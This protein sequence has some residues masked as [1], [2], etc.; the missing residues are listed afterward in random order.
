[1]TKI[2][3]AL[4]EFD[5]DLACN[6]LFML[7]LNLLIHRFCKTKSV[8]KNKTAHD[9]ITLDHELIVNAIFQWEDMLE[10]LDI[11]IHKYIGKREKQTK[12]GNSLK[13]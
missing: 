12:L 6:Y 1:M 8:D 11:I 13:N 5:H 9:G 3:Y 7:G 2:L 10:V 4:I